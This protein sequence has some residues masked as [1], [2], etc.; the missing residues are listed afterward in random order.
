[1]S[2]HP[3]GVVYLQLLAVCVQGRGYGVEE[4]QQELGLDGAV[5][6]RDTVLAVERFQVQVDSYKR[7]GPRGAARGAARVERR[8]TRV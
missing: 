2:L 4:R 8:R 5:G 6:R 1:M 7:G 3:R